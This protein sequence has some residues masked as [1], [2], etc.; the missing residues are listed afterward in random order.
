MKKVLGRQ[1]LKNMGIPWSNVHLRRLEDAGQ[2]PRRIYLGQN[3]C[4]WDEREIHEWLESKAAERQPEA[5]AA[6]TEAEEAKA[7]TRKRRRR[8]GGSQSCLR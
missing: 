7:D 3:T 4:V 1:N 2:F 5:K 6:E 8:A